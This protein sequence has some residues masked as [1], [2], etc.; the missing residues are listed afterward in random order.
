MAAKI[1]TGEAVGLLREAYPGVGGIIDGLGEYFTERVQY[2]A[3][4]LRT[5]DG[6]TDKVEI[7]ARYGQ[8]EFRRPYSET[9]IETRSVAKARSEIRRLASEGYAVVQQTATLGI[10]ADEVYWPSR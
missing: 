10:T 4:L 7:V 8:V 6:N 9:Y 5:A 2:E 1:V 3:V